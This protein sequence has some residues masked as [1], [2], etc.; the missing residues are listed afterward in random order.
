MHRYNGSRSRQESR[1][2]RSRPIPE[3]LRFGSGSGLVEPRFYTWALGT[4]SAGSCHQPAQQPVQS[5]HPR[6][7]DSIDDEAGMA[8][9]GVAAFIADL[10]A[11][12]SS[13]VAGTQYG[14]MLMEVPNSTCGTVSYSARPAKIG[15]NFWE[16]SPRA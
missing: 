1:L 11:A 13:S 16:S 6:R 9:D 10:R 14:R 3:P 8:E 7:G 15:T 2:S 5:Q 4:D 12:Y